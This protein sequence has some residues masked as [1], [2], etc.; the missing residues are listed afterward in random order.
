MFCEIV[1]GKTRD[2]ESVDLN[3][4]VRKWGWSGIPMRITVKLRSFLP[5]YRSATIMWLLQWLWIGITLQKG[6]NDRVIAW[7]FVYDSSGI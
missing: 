3:G 6:V 4:L 7:F 1:L 5:E 2:I